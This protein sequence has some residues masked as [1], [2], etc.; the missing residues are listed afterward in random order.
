M[1]KAIV[2]GSGLEVYQVESLKRM[3]K[4]KDGLKMLKQN[5]EDNMKYFNDEIKRLEDLIN[6]E[7]DD[8]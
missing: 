5:M 6:K 4:I 3:D 2:K 1:R 7:S 8:K